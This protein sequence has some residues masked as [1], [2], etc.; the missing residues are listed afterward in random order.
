[1]SVGIYALKIDCIK[2]NIIEN[3][4]VNTIQ[5]KNKDKTNNIRIG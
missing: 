4:I 2:D 1:M 5:Y 3:D